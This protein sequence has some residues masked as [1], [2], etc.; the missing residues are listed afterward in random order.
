MSVRD[1]FNNQKILVESS[2]S[3]GKDFQFAESAK[4][5]DKKKEIYDELVPHVDYSIPDRFAKF[6]SAELYYKS[7]F[8]YIISEYPYDGSEFEKNSFKKNLNHPERFIFDNIYPKHNGHAILSADGWGVLA[9]S[10]IDGYGE[11]VSKEYIDFK[12][13]PNISS[14]VSS[15][16]RELYE[17]NRRTNRFETKEEIARRAGVG[18]DLVHGDR[19]SSLKTN[20]NN[21][22]TLEFWLKKSSFDNTKTK[23]EVIF[24]LTNS[25]VSSSN[26][27]GRLTLS[28]T[29]TAG[30]SPFLLT[31][32]SGT[33]GFYERALG[34]T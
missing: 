14:T 17:I 22:V 7:A 30:N 34:H 20:F 19:K 4:N 21:G 12:G 2:G 9:G 27:Y 10:L 16:K 24:D 8:E 23:K 25:E 28:L 1:L 11:P 26:S 5:A 29:G 6:G 33:A 13:G 15:T 32:Q 31:V 3:S 18:T